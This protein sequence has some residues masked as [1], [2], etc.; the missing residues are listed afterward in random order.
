MRFETVVLIPSYNG[1]HLLKECL[2]SLRAQTYTG[3]TI[4]VAD[5]GSSD[6]TATYCREHFPEVRVLESKKNR[7]FAKTVNGGLRDA[8]YRYAPRY[9]AILNNDTR[10]DK[11]WLGALVKRIKSDP[12]TAAVTSNM[13]FFDHPDIVN[14]HGGTLDWN[15]DGY[16]INFGIHRIR[17]KEKS[18]RVLGSCWGATLV[19]SGALR[20]IGLLDETFNAYF[21]D[22]DWSWRANILGYHVFF[23]KNAV[24]YH[25]HSASY[26]GMRYKKLF[27]CKRNALR[28]ALKNYERTNLPHEMV[29][30][31]IGYWFA[32]VGYFQTNRHQLPFGKKIVYATIPLFSLLWNLLHLPSAV[33]ERRA[34]QRKRKRKDNIVFNL[35]RQDPTPAREWIKGLKSKMPRVSHLRN[36]VEEISV[37]FKRFA[38]N[39]EHRFFLPLLNRAKHELVFPMLQSAKHKAVLPLVYRVRNINRYLFEHALHKSRELKSF[40]LRVDEET[41][42][43]YFEVILTNLPFSLAGIRKK[44]L[45]K[46][47]SALVVDACMSC[48]RLSWY[49][50]RV[51]LKRL[52]KKIEVAGRELKKTAIHWDDTITFGKAINAPSQLYF[53]LRL[54]EESGT[55]QF[56]EDKM[57][58]VRNEGSRLQNMILDHVHYKKLLSGT[59]TFFLKLYSKMYLEEGFIKY[60]T[61]RAHAIWN[62]EAEY[63]ESGP[64]E[65]ITGSPASRVKP[66]FPAIGGL[67]PPSQRKF[68][69]NI[70]GF[71]D[72]ESGVGEA[73][74]TI[75]RAV[76]RARIPYALLNSP[77]CPHRRKDNEF[78]KKFT[79]ENPYAI[80]I[81]TFY[82]DVFQDELR[83]WGKEKFE[84]RYNIAYW[85]WELSRLPD[86]WEKLF[87]RVDEIWTPSTFVA[88]AIRHARKKMKCTVI[89]HAISPGHAP[90]S[91]SH[92]SLDK[93][94]F[95]FLFMFDFYSIFE[96]K[97]P[98]ATVR[99]FKKAFSPEEP[100]ELIIKCSNSEIDPK[101]FRM[102]EEEVKHHRI[103]IIREY[104]DRE[105]VNSLLNLCDA[106]VS[107]HRSEGFGLTIAEAMSFGKPVIATNYSGNV[108]FMTRENS[109]PISYTLVPLKEDYDGYTKGNV[110]AEPDEEE[111]A[112]RM[113]FVFDQRDAALHKGTLGRREIISHVSPPAIARLV[114]KRIKGLRMRHIG[115]Q[116]EI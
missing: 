71:L 65:E 56:P 60:L 95:V 102:L 13:L 103:R 26:R 115:G 92:F 74:R 100:A 4:I 51:N 37:P 16:D 30:I 67:T 43:A 23:E 11:E 41:M 77:R 32:V 46:E 84:G 80:N 39:A 73:A 53:Y 105:E 8:V 110:W 29:Y 76:E 107:L 58:M 79:S 33:R 109:F 44:D 91:R 3:F 14:S 1:K 35:V 88:S 40:L 45:L 12:R 10:A 94:D 62:G 68:G 90:Y 111:A 106:Y 19:R 34:I 28:A 24:V 17:E 89:P 25:K 82:G 15:G 96:R 50:E 2:L 99:A 98:L 78:S 66:G 47:E 70:F 20:T 69:V 61:T 113:R 21:E 63:R 93:N 42:N 49:R 38:Q 31:L 112:Q 36:R 55:T 72:S 48:L 64:P 83:A 87:D 114:A 22:L 101:N 54:I 27:F 108:D 5:D 75:A 9:I 104:L 86:S 116:K 85:A 57:N 81:I 52:A 59:P 97:N 7:G 6:G 18:R